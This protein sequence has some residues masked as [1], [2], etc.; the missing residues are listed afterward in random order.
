MKVP[1]NHSRKREA[2]IN[3]GVSILIDFFCC[4]YMG[5]H[6]T[7]FC[8]YTHLIILYVLFGNLLFSIKHCGYL[9]VFNHI[10]ITYSFY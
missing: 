8:F 10:D 4:I 2:T 9:Y 6:T 1:T 3:K 7:E 5:R